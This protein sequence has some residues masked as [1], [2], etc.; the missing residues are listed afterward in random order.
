MIVLLSASTALSHTTIYVTQVIE[1]LMCYEETWEEV[2][3]RV[4][5]SIMR[6]N[7]PYKVHFEMVTSITTEDGK[8]AKVLI[9]YYVIRFF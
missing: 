1:S 7:K 9:S 2:V 5:K 4:K 3:D 6:N 8:K